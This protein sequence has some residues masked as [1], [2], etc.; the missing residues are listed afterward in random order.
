MPA[1]PLDAVAAL[2][3][4]FTFATAT[5]TGAIMLIPRMRQM[6]A[7]QTKLQSDTEVQELTSAAG[8]ID[9]AA[10]SLKTMLE[11]VPGGEN[12]P[13]KEMAQVVD[14]TAR[15]MLAILNTLPSRLH[16][17]EQSLESLR[18]EMQDL[19]HQIEGLSREPRL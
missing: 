16:E 11:A 17:A 15:A 1:I 3:A 10:R 14:A 6:R 2:I 9:A 8:A 19:R 4:V 18:A 12:V 7:E 13:R 5:V